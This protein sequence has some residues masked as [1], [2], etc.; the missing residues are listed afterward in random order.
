V[1]RIPHRG[2]FANMVF[3]NL[4]VMMTGLLLKAKVRFIS[5]K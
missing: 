3:H 4:C 2:V 5:W 1:P